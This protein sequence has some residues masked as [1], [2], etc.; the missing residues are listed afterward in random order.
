MATQTTLQNLGTHTKRVAA[1][2][3]PLFLALVALLAMNVALYT[4]LSPKQPFAAS[5]L[6]FADD[7]AEDSIGRWLRFGGDWKV[8]DGALF[9]EQPDAKAAAIFVR[10]SLDNGQPYRLGVQL[11]LSNPQ[12]SGGI[13]FNAQY[14]RIQQNR[15]IVEVVARDGQWQL[16][17]GYL[18][19]TAE[20]KSQAVV[21]LNLPADQP[22]DARLAIDAGTAT[23]SVA[24][25]D[26]TL[27]RDVP[28][29]Y[30]DGIVGLTASSGPVRFD[31]LS[32]VATGEA[33]AAPTQN[34]PQPDRV[35]P[36]QANTLYASQFTGNLADSG[37]TPFAGDWIFRDG[38][39]VQQQLD[40]YDLGIAYRDTFE[41]YRF[42]VKFQLEQ[43]V[44]AGLLFNLPDSTSKNRGH[45]VR[46]A[47]DG[48]GVFWGHFDDQGV[49]TGEGFV[50]TASPGTATHI[51][52]VLSDVSTYSILLDGAILA[53]GIALQ[54]PRGHIG[55]TTSQS[56]AAFQKVDVAS[57]A[58]G[59]AAVATTA[60]VTATDTASGL[61]ANTQTLSGEWVK[62]GATIRQLAADGVD[63]ITGI[64][65]LA[66]Q[67][68]LAVDI[69]LPADLGDAGGGLI[70][71]MPKRDDIRGAYMVRFGDGGKTLFWG[72]YSDAGDFAGQ[73]SAATTLEAGKAHQLTVTV[74][75]D[76]FDIAIDGTLVAPNIPL[77]STF[78]WIGLTSFRGPVV[79]SNL[80]LTLGGAAK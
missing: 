39:L 49:F 19:D 32:V 7:F 78:G 48:T 30:K 46:Y 65:V 36:D 76:N 33:A 64:G 34:T 35:L 47:D 71:H 20:F 38:A 75:Q 55:L 24:L 17:C 28:L 13:S 74:K 44:G 6:P 23:Y 66:E 73:G 72:R 62:E 63:Y 56:V 12:Q 58:G 45:M 18:K 26:Q 16:I 40:G 21:P 79:F 22:L 1:L 10:L 70:F 59:A 77:A 43:G 53:E 5:E 25:D 9:Q 42:S 14:P 68:T 15:H 61:L 29:I 3:L 67:Y 37:W 8:R 27:V 57:L 80:Q 4:R 2:L 11:G 51:L 41:S 50:P 60:V 69:L 52:E 54:N 31:N